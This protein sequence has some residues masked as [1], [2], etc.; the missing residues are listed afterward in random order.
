MPFSSKQTNCGLTIK[1]KTVNSIADDGKQELICYFV[2]YPLL[3]YFF[4]GGGCHTY[5]NAVKSVKSMHSFTFSKAFMVGWN[6]MFDTPG[7]SA[8]TN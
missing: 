1:K 7:L 3:N 5:V 6:G 8:A 4:R 2:V